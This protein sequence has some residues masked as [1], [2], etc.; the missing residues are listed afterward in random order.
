M[1]GT[2][3]LVCPACSPIIYADHQGKHD[4]ASHLAVI[5]T[6]PDQGYRTFK[7]ACCPDC[8]ERLAWFPKDSAML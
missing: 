6:E 1:S 4:P 7:P 3:V 5:E 2:G 8:G